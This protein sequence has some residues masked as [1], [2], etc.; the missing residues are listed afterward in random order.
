LPRVRIHFTPL[1]SVAHQREVEVEVQGDPSTRE[2]VGRISRDNPI[3]ATLPDD[4]KSRIFTVWVIGDNGNRIAGSAT[5]YRYIPRITPAQ[6]TKLPDVSELPDLALEQD[7][8]AVNVPIDP[9]SLPAAEEQEIEVEVRVAPETTS[10]PAEALEVGS[11]TTAPSIS[12][13]VQPEADEQAVFYRYHNVNSGQKTDWKKQTVLVCDPAEYAKVEDFKEGWGSVAIEN[14][15]GL[16]SAAVTGGGLNLELA[17]APS[18]FASPGNGGFPDSPFASGGPSPFSIKA[19]MP[20]SRFELPEVDAGAC[21]EFFPQTWPELDV[22]GHAPNRSPFASGEPNPFAS[23]GRAC[24][25]NPFASRDDASPLRV[26]EEIQ[27]AKDDIEPLRPYRPVKP[28]QRVIAQRHKS[29]I[30]VWG[31]RYRAWRLRRYWWWRRILNK[32]WEWYLDWD[33][34]GGAGTTQLVTLPAEI[35]TVVAEPIVEVSVVDTAG[36]IATVSYDVH[37]DWISGSQIN[38]AVVQKERA[39]VAAAG[40]AWSHIFAKPFGNPPQMAFGPSGVNPSYAGFET[41]T[42]NDASGYL[43]FPGGPGNEGPQPDSGN[44]HLHIHGDPLPQSAG[45]TLRLLLQAMGA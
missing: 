17:D 10:D 9:P 43:M 11:T 3:L 31:W 22:Q 6:E 21:H 12:V 8:P 14:I 5:R 1:D 39:E 44:V 35:V 37:T 13:P 45:G 25:I 2:P 16:P 19:K 18:P 7:G 41:V 27:V 23:E 20:Y 29:R 33:P 26:T 28:G 24:D 40:G 4:G 32:K 36:A 38:V 34:L 15:L 42:P 30:T